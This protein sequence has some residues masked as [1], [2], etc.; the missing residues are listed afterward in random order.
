E[1][2]DTPSRARP[3]RPPSTGG[4]PVRRRLGNRAMHAS[5][6]AL[7]ASAIVPDHWGPSR[8]DPRPAGVRREDR[9]DAYDRPRPP[10]RLRPRYRLAR[11]LPPARTPR[12]PVAGGRRRRA[13]RAQPTAD[14][15]AAARRAPPARV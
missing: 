8:R 11:R 5:A 7:D 4:A 9:P 10:T 13:H 6:I 1:T 14:P 12:G 3:P 2:H 15:G